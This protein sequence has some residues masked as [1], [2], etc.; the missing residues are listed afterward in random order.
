MV[1][2]AG[3]TANWVRDYRTP[4]WARVFWRNT[5]SL[6]RFLFKRKGLKRTRAILF[7]LVRPMRRTTWFVKARNWLE[8]HIEHFEQGEQGQGVGFM[9]SR[10][11]VLTYAN[12]IVK[13]YWNA[14]KLGVPMYN[15]ADFTRTT[16]WTSQ[17][18]AAMMDPPDLMRS[19]DAFYTMPVAQA[20]AV[21]D[22][23]TKN[24][25]PRVVDRNFARIFMANQISN[26]GSWYI[27][28]RIYCAKRV[29]DREMRELGIRDPPHLRPDPMPQP[30]TK[31][32]IYKD[33]IFEERM[34][35]QKYESMNDSDQPRRGFVNRRRSTI[36]PTHG[37]KYGYSTVSSSFSLNK[38]SPTSTSSRQYTTLTQ[39]SNINSSGE[40]CDLLPLKRFVTENSKNEIF[41][42]IVTKNHPKLKQLFS[43]KNNNNSTH[44]SGY[45]PQVMAF[46]T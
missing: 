34:H 36:D 8:D 32:P 46:D 39:R 43:R 5:R 38:N 25:Y 7:L 26:G 44:N 28:C 27:L 42:N 3:K 30:S 35:Q 10:W 6:N 1:G 23:E 4:G 16:G 12:S 11:S 24:F 29:L 31:D 21:L 40:Y 37:S 45:Q 20:K 19:Q 33:Q 18:E 13:G 17:G 41:I 15:K 22:I 2:N 14:F 9:Q